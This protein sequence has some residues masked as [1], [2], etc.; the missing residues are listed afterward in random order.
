MANPTISKEDFNE[1]GYELTHI[2]M[3]DKDNIWSVHYTKIINPDYY[4][5]EICIQWFCGTKRYSIYRNTKTLRNI[6]LF[7]GFLNSIEDLKFIEQ[8]WD[9]SRFYDIKYEK[10]TI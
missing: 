4:F 6:T 2:C 9:L 7:Q 10:E 1:S 3:E 5:D 8:L